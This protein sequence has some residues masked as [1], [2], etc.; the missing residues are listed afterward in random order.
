MKGIRFGN[1][2]AIWKLWYKLNYMLVFPPYLSLNV[3]LWFYL[4]MKLLQSNIILK[5]KNNHE[6]SY[7]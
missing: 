2:I 3:H 5:Q 7:N 6:V 4:Y 1:V